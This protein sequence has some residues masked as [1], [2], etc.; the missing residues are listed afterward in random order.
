MEEAMFKAP[1][2]SLVIV[3]AACCLPALSQDAKPAADDRAKQLFQQMEN[4]LAKA[5][6]LQ[7]TFEIDDEFSAPGDPKTTRLLEGSLFL[8]GGNRVRQEIKE[9]TVGRPMFKL[10]VSDGTRW[11]WHDKGSPPHLVNKKLGDNLN[12][13]FA[14]ALARSGLSLPTL[15]L[16]PV[17]TA[18]AKERFPVSGFRLG[19]KEKVGERE[20]QRLEYRL[21]IK[22]QDGPAGEKIFFSVTVWLD[23]GT[24]LP[25]KRV[26]TQ[27][28]LGM[29]TTETYRTLVLNGEIEAKKFEL[30]KVTHDTIV[31]P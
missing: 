3:L 23:P 9:R 30:P 4:R 7:C 14:T 27:T 31:Q 10:L 5:K 26:I 16:P 6:T 20:A 1:V 19:T 12:A 15:P 28:V 11:W 22:G 24:S 21:P 25:I 8:A 18:D 17:E 13:D 2:F 29:K